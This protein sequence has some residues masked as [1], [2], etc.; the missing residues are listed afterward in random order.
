MSA[1]LIEAVRKLS[2]SELESLGESLLDFQTIADLEAWLSDSRPQ[3]S[4][5]QI[6]SDDAQNALVKDCYGHHV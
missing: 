3:Q 2:I 4:E 5:L 6:Y 1:E